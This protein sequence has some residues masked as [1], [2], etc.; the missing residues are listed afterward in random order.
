MSNIAHV[1]AGGVRPRRPGWRRRRAWA[2]ALAWLLAPPALVA[3]AFQLQ[4]NHLVLDLPVMANATGYFWWEEQR[5]TLAYADA[6]GVLYLHR[7]VGTGYTERQGWRTLQDVFA[8]F[9]RRFEQQGW[10]SPAQGVDEAALPES[11]LLDPSHVRGYYR[12]TD[13]SERATVAAW[14]IGGSVQGFH[15]VLVTQRPSWAR[16]IGQDL[17]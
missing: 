2:M 13:P 11:R 17:D 1:E 6:W 14:P 12:A 15:V 10:V 4:P 9:D 7:R 16:R 3:A 5:S 8:E